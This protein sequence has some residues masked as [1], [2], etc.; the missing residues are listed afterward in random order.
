MKTIIAGSRD[1]TDITLLAEAIAQ[2]G[3]AI[4]EVVCGMAKGADRIGIDWATEQGIPVKAFPADWTRYGRGAGPVRNREMAEYADALIA[5][6]D[7]KSRGTKHMINLAK[8]QGLPT[9]VHRINDRA[10]VDGGTLG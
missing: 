7:G 1:I 5:L 10:G 3:F 4:T 8:Q 2:S 9:Y 6:W